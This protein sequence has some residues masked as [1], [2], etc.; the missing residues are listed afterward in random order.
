M[1]YQYYIKTAWLMVNTLDMITKDICLLC[2]FSSYW[3]VLRSVYFRRECFSTVIVQ[4]SDDGVIS[5]MYPN[6]I[7]KYRNFCVV[8]W[9]QIQ[10]CPSLLLQL[11]QIYFFYN[12]TIH[13]INS[14]NDN[15]TTAVID[16][17]FALSNSLY[18]DW[19]ILNLILNLNYN[20]FA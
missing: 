16:N 7:S 8:T 9:V 4:L 5:W 13:W 19:G 11:K 1:L 2:T 14:N 3:T 15:R 12:T 6:N 20:R 17:V 18:K 10:Y